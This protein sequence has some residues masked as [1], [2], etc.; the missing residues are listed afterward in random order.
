VT[1]ALGRRDFSYWGTGGWTVAK[2]CYRI[3]L[4]S[5]SRDIAAQKVVSVGG[6]SCPGAVAHI[7]RPA[8]KC[9]DTRRFSFRLH[10]T[11]GAR[12]VRVVVYVNGKRKLSRRGRNITRV[13]IAR[14]PKKRF[15]VKIVTTQN[16]G[17]QIISTRVYNGCK[18]S[19]PTVRHGHT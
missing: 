15:V 2:G 17:A 10:H 4:G 7:R 6:A 13:S 8:S 12:V 19:R 14:L 11:S 16:N 9:V 1:L 18:K 5:S 3:M